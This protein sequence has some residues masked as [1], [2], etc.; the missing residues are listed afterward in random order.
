MEAEWLADYG[1]RA[2]ASTASNPYTSLKLAQS[3]TLAN[4]LYR[5]NAWLVV[6]Q[7]RDAPP[8]A[9]QGGRAGRRSA[10]AAAKRAAKALYNAMIMPVARMLRKR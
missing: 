9:E 8:R 6:Y 4:D 7:H 5:K 3:G 10:K 1:W 2:G